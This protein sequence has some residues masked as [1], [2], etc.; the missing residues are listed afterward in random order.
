MGFEVNVGLF[1]CTDQEDEAYWP[2]DER[3]QYLEPEVYQAY[4]A[5]SKR[6]RRVGSEFPDAPAGERLAEFLRSDAGRRNDER[7][8]VKPDQAGTAPVR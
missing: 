3:E 6:M 8:V 4:E 2:V 5:P 1:L 7:F